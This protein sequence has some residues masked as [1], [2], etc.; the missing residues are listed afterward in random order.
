MSR[1]T[2]A[3]VLGAGLGTRLRPLTEDLPKPLMAA[4]GGIAQAADP[5][6][7]K[8]THYFCT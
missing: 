2:Q 4:Y 3:F 7:S 1:I 6:L 5:D 8:A